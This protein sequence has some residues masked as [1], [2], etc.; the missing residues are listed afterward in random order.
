MIRIR[1]F[2]SILNLGGSYTKRGSSSDH[3]GRIAIRPFAA[4]GCKSYLEH[5]I[6]LVGDPFALR[7]RQPVE[8]GNSAADGGGDSS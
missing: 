7:F 6:R 4:F 8:A 2:C 1:S 5:L 3:H